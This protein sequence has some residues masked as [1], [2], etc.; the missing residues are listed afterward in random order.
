MAS[1]QILEIH[2]HST[3]SDGAKSPSE[4]ARLM[5]SHKVE[6]WAL[7]DHDTVEGC[8][9]G[10]V[11]AL[12]LG[13]H[14]IAGI[15]VSADL[16][17]ASIHV[18][19][20]DVDI[21]NQRLGTYGETMKE[22][23]HERMAEMVDRM[24]HLG[25]EVTLEEVIEQSGGGNLGRPHLAKA[26]V[27]RGHVDRLQKAFNRWLSNDGP[28]YVPMSRPSVGESIDMIIDAGG[29]AVLAHPGRYGDVSEHLPRWKER[30][31]WGLE[32]RHPSH[33]GYTERR[34]SRMAVEFGLGRTASNDWHG[35]KE[36]EYQRLGKVRFPIEWREPFLEALSFG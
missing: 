13:V 17:G 10:R 2:S 8:E 31:L 5:A 23:R 30:G 4:L 20:Y 3:A 19:G 1:P 15:E 18:L 36:G 25:F 21:T 6:V 22:G 33:N 16:E 29:V 35:Q 11:A 24:C 7:T 28:G 27:A 34:L 14:F 12:D 26:L 9:E 32:V